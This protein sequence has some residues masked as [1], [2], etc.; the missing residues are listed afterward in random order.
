[1][2]E[3]K[4]KRNKKKI[5]PPKPIAKVETNKWNKEEIQLNHK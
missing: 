2:Q 1:M 5:K 3:M 4:R